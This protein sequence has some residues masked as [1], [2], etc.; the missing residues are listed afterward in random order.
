[1]RERA[2]N[3]SCKGGNSGRTQMSVL[4]HSITSA[5]T[6]AQLLY[7]Q[8]VMAIPLYQQVQNWKC[9][10]LRMNRAT[11]ANWVLLYPEI[12]WYLYAST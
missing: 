12:T 11:L 1:M 5:S 3:D 8:Y 6:V 9:A 10:G 4:K 7:D 2:G